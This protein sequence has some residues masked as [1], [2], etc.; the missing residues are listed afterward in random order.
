MLSTNDDRIA[1]LRRRLGSLSWFMR[2]LKEPIARRANHEDECTG[3][4]WEGRF[5]SQAL[6]DDAAVLTGMVYVD[7]NPIR[8]KEAQCPEDSQYTSIKR[9]I[10]I[11]ELDRPLAPVFGD[12]PAPLPE[13]KE[14][15]YLRLVDWAGR[16]TIAG[17]GG[18]IDDSL[19]GILTR[20]GAVPRPWLNQMNAVETRYRRAI[21][22]LDALK[23]RAEAL[24]QRWL[25]GMGFARALA[26]D[27]LTAS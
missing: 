4:F 6:L 9:R 15:E 26:R 5:D 20:L 11:D 27:Q 1:E 16:T 19:P 18:H 21:G 2:C 7:L 24:Q 25:H 14:A 17:K 22:T 3:R 23:A 13:L 10:D 8:S 12:T